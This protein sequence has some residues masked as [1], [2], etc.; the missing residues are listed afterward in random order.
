DRDPPGVVQP[1]LCPLPNPLCP[2]PNRGVQV[3]ASVLLGTHVEVSDLVVRYGRRTALAG[4]DL[5]LDT[6]VYGLLGPNGA[7]K[8]TLI[9][10]L[11]SIAKPTSG[12]VSLLGQDLRDHRSL[13]Q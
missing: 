12:R 11:A 2:L 1:A 4:L 6:G 5:K 13:R 8:T 9:R 3:T 10:V 7:G